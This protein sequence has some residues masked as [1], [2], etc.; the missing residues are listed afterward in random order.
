MRQRERNARTVLRFAKK[1]PEQRVCTDTG[2]RTILSD[3]NT[4]VQLSAISL[5]I[6]FSI[7]CAGFVVSKFTVRPDGRTPFQYLLGTPYVSL[8]CMFGESVFALI[9]DH[10][11]RASKLT[12][13]W[14]SGCWWGRNMVC[15]SADQF[16]AHLLETSGADVKRSKHEGRSGIVSW[17][18]ILEYTDQFWNYVETKECRQQRPRWK[19]LQYFHLHRRLKNT[20]SNASSQQQRRSR[21]GGQD[22]DGALRPIL[23]ESF[24]NE[25]DRQSFA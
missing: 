17:K 4:G 2:T 15:F 20:Y 19:F 18:W 14:T 3:A 1:T 8:L 7:R 16:A 11:V 21:C 25:S 23:R 24:E 10:E 12:S 9:P 22:E 6:P 13:R 5:T